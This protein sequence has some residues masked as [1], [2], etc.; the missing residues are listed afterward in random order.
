MAHMSSKYN[1]IT[2]PSREMEIATAQSKKRPVGELGISHVPP[3]ECVNLLYVIDQIC[4]LG[5]A[6]STLLEVIRRLSPERFKC[7]VVTFRSNP[8]LEALKKLPC[9]LHVIPLRRTYDLNAVKM[10]LRLRRLIREENV[11]IVHT[12]FETSDLWAAPIA[13][14][15]GRPIL[16]SSRRDMGFM[17]T[18]KH[19]LA[20]PFANLM[21]DQVLAVSDEVRSY[22][23]KH[24]HL[25][26]ERVETLYN[27]V[28]LQVV[29]LKAGEGNARLSLGL[30]CDVPVISSVANI[31]YVK[32]IDVLVGAATRV[33]REFPT[34]VF[35]IVGG[36]L[37]PD[38]FAHLKKTVDSRGLAENV[39]FLGSQSN[40]FPILRSSDAFCLPSRNE[41]FSNALIQ[42]MGCALPCVAT[43][44][45]GNSEALT[46]GVS[47][48]LVPSEDEEA[49]ADRI[50]RFIRD[51]QKARN[52]GQAA[53]HTVESRFSMNAM[54]KRLMDI[55]DELLAAK[56]A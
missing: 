50:L 22:C 32:G 39:R 12:F 54:M 1:R 33:C 26:P 28:D 25:P 29:D 9:R 31:R 18:R 35:L 43:R 15:S 55:Y 8:N 7:S 51:P 23:L 44:V 52:M 45:G 27:G 37:E 40:P 24:D 14:L 3:R 21:F 16:V 46:E 2:V 30:R 5:G 47:G 48:Y 34:A 41:G 19:H 56:N 11:S 42:A 17:R 53:R 38:T 10:A 49:M 6:E 20:Y 4:Q 13:K 36:V